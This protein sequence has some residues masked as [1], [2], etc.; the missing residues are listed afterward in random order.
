MKTPHALSL[1]S[2]QIVQ[3]IRD[4]V[5]GRPLT[6]SDSAADLLDYVCS[7]VGAPASGEEHPPKTHW[8]THSELRSLAERLGWPVDVSEREVALIATRAIYRILRA[9]KLL[10]ARQLAELIFQRALDPDYTG[11]DGTLRGPEWERLGDLL[12]TL[13]D[14]DRRGEGS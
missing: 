4:C 1:S 10:Q 3:L 5:A 8:A 6:C 14:L 7:L 9:P 2:D 13:D 12:R 11:S